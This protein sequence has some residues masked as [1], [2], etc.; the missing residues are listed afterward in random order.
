MDIQKGLSGFQLDVLQE[1]S[2]IGAG[3]AATALA[4]MLNK[5]IDMSVPRAGI[6]PFSDIYN[7]VGQEEDMVACV[8]FSV[9]G[10]ADSRIFFLL[11][12]ENS[13]CLI[14]MLF[15]NEPG[16]TKQMTEMGQ[17]TIQELANILTGS[18]LNA[19]AEVTKLTFM[20]SVPAFAF[21]M[22]GAVLSSA[23]LES[24]YFDDQ[25]LIIETQFFQNEIK[26]NGHFFLIPEANSLEVIFNSLGLQFDGGM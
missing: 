19:F 24:G 18:F 12:E 8:N 9:H 25:V 15:G 16:T 26:I 22:L 23:F 11:T 10:E 13:Y 7:L 1:I 4:K 21:D 20:P 3:N 14:D 5:R 6:L 17:S 2:N